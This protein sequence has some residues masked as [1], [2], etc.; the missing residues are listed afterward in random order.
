[1]SS[2]K[3]V[4]SIIKKLYIN[5]LRKKAAEKKAAA[6]AAAAEEKAA[7]EVEAEAAA[8][9]NNI[10]A[11][12]KNIF[13]SKNV[14]PINIKSI[15]NNEILR[16]MNNIFYTDKIKNNVTKKRKRKE[17]NNSNI[18]APQLKKAKIILEEVENEIKKLEDT[19][20][21]LSLKNTRAS[22][23]A[24]TRKLNILKEKEKALKL[25]L[26]ARTRS[27]L[28]KLLENKK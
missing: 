26:R 28:K 8:E 25:I 20:V 3:V 11:W 18:G 16:L 2:D 13:E 1:M 21:R 24:I 7:A 27:E 17:N 5:P 12:V 15:K 22:K 10:N 6:A 4:N 14:N 19:N 9:T 23:A